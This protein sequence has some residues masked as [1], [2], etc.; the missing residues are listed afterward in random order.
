MQ[1][2]INIHPD[3]QLNGQHFDHAQEMM[4]FVKKSFPKDHNFIQQL[5][6]NQTFIIAKTS[7]STGNPKAIRLKK[8]YLV[9]SAKNTIDFFRL[10]P[11]TTALLNL[12]SDFI[13]GKMMWIRALIGGW[14]LDVISPENISISKQ[15]KSHHYDFGA[16]VPLQAYQNSDLLHKIDKLIIGGGVVTTALQNKI[17]HQKNKIFAT[18]GMTET[19]THI[20]VKA[21]NKAAKKDFYHNPL[22]V[23]AYQLLNNISI[24]QDQRNCLVVEAPEL[25]DETI[26]T[27]D[28]VEILD[29]KHFKWL[30]RYDNIINSGGLKFMPEQIE[31]KLTA[32]I[33]E[34]FFIAGLP[35]E[36]LGEKIVMII[37]SAHKK[38]NLN[39]KKYLAPYEIPQSIFYLPQ[40]KKTTSGKIK[41]NEILE[42]LFKH[43]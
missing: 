14:H 38:E 30:G 26:I 31:A 41:R 11:K 42:D 7:G 17:N 22:S 33:P 5:F 27:N 35:D 6:D 20:A 1:S 3:F 4:A 21:L 15:L 36:K 43:N 12:S 29:E 28:I 40:F 24:R 37:E 32:F 2:Y 23:D 19:I 25:S 13:A 34:N 16:M 10:T 8:K 9:N 18:Y 39:F